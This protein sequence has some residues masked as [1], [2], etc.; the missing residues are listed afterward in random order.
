MKLKNVLTGD[1]AGQ[2]RE[3]MSHSGWKYF[4]QL[5]DQ[6]LVTEFGRAVLTTDVSAGNFNLQIVKA[7]YDGAASL[8]AQVAKLKE[9]MRDASE[10]REK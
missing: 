5:L 4:V 7:R 8:A 3:M 2:V 1:Q 6:G 9:A 10:D